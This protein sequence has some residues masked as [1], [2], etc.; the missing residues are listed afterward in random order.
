M[1]HP[2]KSSLKV[3][4]A[5]FAAAVETLKEFNHLGQSVLAQ[6]NIDV[7]DRTVFYP[8]KLRVDLFQAVHEKFGDAGLTWVGMESPRQF[9]SIEDLHHSPT[10]LR[11]S[12]L[13]LDSTLLNNPLALDQF[14]RQYLSAF[15]EEMSNIL[16]ASTLD[17]D[18]PVGMFLHQPPSGLPLHY[19]LQVNSKLSMTYV[20]WTRGV[21]HFNLRTYL[22]DGWDFQLTINKELSQELASHSEYFYDLVIRP[23]AAG[24][25]QAFYTLK[26]RL[27]CREALLKAALDHTFKQEQALKRVHDKTMESIRYAAAVQLN[28]LPKV[29][30]KHG[31]KDFAVLWEPKDTIGGDTWWLSSE[32]SPG[33]VT[34]AVIDCTGHG[35]P[36]AMT[37]MLVSNTLTR[38]FAEDPFCTLEAAAAGI[39]QALAQSF[40]SFD[41]NSDVANGCDLVLIQR[42]PHAH[43]LRVG[44]A[45]I[46]VMHYRNAQKK[47]DWI[48]SPRNGIS[49]KPSADLP[50]AIRHIEYSVGDR[51]L[52]TTDGLT[53]QVGGGE[54]LRSFGYGRTRAILESTPD[55]S[56]KEVAQSLVGAMD[57]WRGINERRDDVT[58]VCIDL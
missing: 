17:A 5:F 36:G 3:S 12:A 29:S 53:D 57:A 1:H 16:L 2:E 33:P 7:I 44:L 8:N 49:A 35:V 52:I 42:V 25:N 41:Q 27:E 20:T 22:P 43:Q 31:F 56:V 55:K 48:E 13:K 51:L 32:D 30:P 4:G 45:G 47:L 15:S 28:Q 9:V 10:W 18:Y 21:N 46:D 24:Q 37:A 50:M 14:F 54:R 58:L 40:G 6:H 38:L 23:M 39:G 26:D 11:L 19:L 34:L